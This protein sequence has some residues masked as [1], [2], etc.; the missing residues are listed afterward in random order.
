MDS[1]DQINHGTKLSIQEYAKQNRD[2]LFSNLYMNILVGFHGYSKPY[3]FFTKLGNKIQ[4]TSFQ[5]KQMFLKM[6]ETLYVKILEFPESHFKL[7][8]AIR[9]NKFSLDHIHLVE[10][11]KGKRLY[12]RQAN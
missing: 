8:D 10:N 11:S 7:Y 3:A 6:E 4:K 2:K 12:M 5:A 1:K 9:R